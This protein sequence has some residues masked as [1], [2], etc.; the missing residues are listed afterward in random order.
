MR[1][2]FLRWV[3]VLWLGLAG[4]GCGGWVAHRLVQAPNTYPTWFAPKARVTLDFGAA[5]LT[6]FPTRFADVGAP[7]A[8]LCYRIVEPANYHFRTTSTNWVEGQQPHF[9]FSF[10]GTVPGERLANSRRPRGTVVL[11]HGYG[12]EHAVMLPWAL[13]LAE[14]GWRC[15]LVDLRGHG[16]STGRRIYFGVQES[17]DL[18]ALLDE[19]TR[20]D[21]LAGS[22]AVLG[23]SYGAALALRW[24][25][26]EPRVG[27][28]VALAPYA[29]LSA[30]AL[31]IRREYASWFPRSCLEAGLRELPSLLKVAPG[32]LDTTAPLRRSPVTA[33]FVAGE[34]DK[35]AGVADVER[36][37]ALGAPKSRWLVVPHATHEALLYFFD[38]LVGP[39]V[40]WLNEYGVVEE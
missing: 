22:V 25:A 32:E 1:W 23:E 30:A 35:I 18:S 16:R 27:A 13:R 39:V 9:R 2:K 36:L 38:D 29:E 7:A 26:E 20:G 5:M 19:L 17:R 21:G 14:E 8:R 11:L 40:G 3:P 6:N 4:T 10:E 31:N 33:L 34:E 24:K 37:H 12:L 28:V 15:V